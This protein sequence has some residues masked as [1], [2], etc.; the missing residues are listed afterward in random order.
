MGAPHSFPPLHVLKIAMS[1]RSAFLEVC[2][3]LLFG[4]CFAD[5]IRLAGNQPFPTHPPASF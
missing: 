2:V 1:D 3:D 5:G 4:K